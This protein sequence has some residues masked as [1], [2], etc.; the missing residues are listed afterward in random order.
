MIREKE[1]EKFIQLRSLFVPGASDPDK[2]FRR[3]KF[4]VSQEMLMSLMNRSINGTEQVQELITNHLGTKFAQE[5]LN[6][7]EIKSERN[8][9]DNCIS[10]EMSAVVLSKREFMEIIKFCVENYTPPLEDE[11]ADNSQDETE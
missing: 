10:Y 9:R 7:L 1:I 4:D 2:L 11:N 5:C 6:N 8:W 3:I